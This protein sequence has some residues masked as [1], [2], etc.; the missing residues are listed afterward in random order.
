MPF[1]W[2]RPTSSPALRAA[3]AVA[4]VPADPHRARTTRVVEPD[5]I[6]PPRPRRGRKTKIRR[7]D[8]DASRHTRRHPILRRRTNLVEPDGIEPTTS[9]LQS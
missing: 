9:S 1:F 2:V 6:E 3:A 8:P 7:V 5:G 4:A